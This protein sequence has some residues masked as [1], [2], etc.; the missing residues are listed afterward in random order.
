[1]PDCSKSLSVFQETHLSG[2]SAALP[3]AV[4]FTG[5]VRRRV[6]R[7]NELR[8]SAMP[9]ATEHHRS[10]QGAWFGG[11][12]RDYGDKSGMCT[13][14]RGKCACART[15]ARGEWECDGEMLRGF[16]TVV[17]SLAENASVVRESDRFLAELSPLFGKVVLSVIR[18]PSLARTVLFA[19]VTLAVVDVSTN[20]A[21]RDL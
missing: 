16:P 20:N 18:V 9:L 4:C 8:L 15:K 21:P 11:A 13:S 7:R 3:T 6:V 5:E 12:N 19:R 1:M 14:A 2:S 17:H 10:T